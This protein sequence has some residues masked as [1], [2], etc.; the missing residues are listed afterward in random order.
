MGNSGKETLSYAGHTVFLQLAARGDG[1]ADMDTNRI[2]LKAENISITTSRTIPSFPIP[3]S[4]VA[5]GESLTMAMDMGMA[6]KSIN[7]S[8]IITE[9]MISKRFKGDSFE[10]DADRPN[11]QSSNASDKEALNNLASILAIAV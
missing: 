9:Q 1:G 7:I 8:G 2:G 4:G 3:M 10:E 11:V 5:T 6:N